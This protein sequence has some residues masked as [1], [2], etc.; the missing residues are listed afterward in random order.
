M[1][2]LKELYSKQW[3]R[4]DGTPDQGM[5]DYCIK[6]SKYVDMGDYF[7]NVGDSKPTI[8][9]TMWYDDTTKGPDENFE[10]FRA[11]NLRQNAH[12]FED[13]TSNGR[14]Q[15]WTYVNYYGDKTE[16]KLRGWST[17]RVGEEPRFNDTQYWAATPEEIEAIKKGLDE[18][19]A[20]YEKRLET[21]WKR[22]SNK[23]SA[24]GYWADR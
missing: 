12:T 5:V 17:T 21:Y 3:I 7:L 11:Y 18:I 4:K 13:M 15:I 20:D 19:R 6:H 22:Y 14:T 1:S 9:S 10:N 16:G 24:R 8:E 23:V 2:N